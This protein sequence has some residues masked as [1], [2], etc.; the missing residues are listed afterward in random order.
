MSVHGRVQR[1]TLRLEI[2]GNSKQ[3]L[4]TVKFFHIPY[5]V[6]SSN[7]LYYLGNQLFVKRSQYIRLKNP[8]HMQSEKTCSACASKRNVLELATLRYV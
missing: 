8:L 5:I 2:V 3:Q 7:K 6:A 1:A 4:L